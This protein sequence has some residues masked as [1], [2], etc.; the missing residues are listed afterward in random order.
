M[1]YKKSKANIHELIDP[2]IGD[3][4]YNRIADYLIVGVVI[5]NMITIVLESVES[6]YITPLHPLFDIIEV[7]A[8][9]VFSIEYILRV[10]TSD[11]LYERNPQ[12]SYLKHRV[13]SFLKY[14]F[15]PMGIIDLVAIIASFSWIFKIDAEYLKAFRLLKLFKLNRYSNSL[16]LVGDVLRDKRQELFTTIFLTF[17]L[18]LLA[19]TMMYYLEQEVQPEQFPNIIAAFWWAVATLTTVGYGDVYPVTSWGRL[20]SGVIALLGIG[21]VA[22]PT[23]ILSAAFLEKLEVNEETEVEKQKVRIKGLEQEIEELENKLED[24]YAKAEKERVK[25]R[26]EITTLE[27]ENLILESK[28]KDLIKSQ[29]YKFC[30]SCGAELP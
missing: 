1:N 9:I 3:D 5:L 30:P 20:L 22:L 28:N 4:I 17:L 27:K 15:S 19:S 12:H 11:L 7:F 6:P 16:R 18:I 26:L 24:Y 8:F 14:V 21:I 2:S 13:L 25:L 23:G 10:W 29:K